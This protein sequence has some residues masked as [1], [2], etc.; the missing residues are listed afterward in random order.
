MITIIT[1]HEVTRGVLG[2]FRVSHFSARDRR[3]V[4]KAFLENKLR[5]GSTL[6]GFEEDAPFLPEPWTFSLAESESRVSHVSHPEE[7]V[8]GR[9]RPRHAASRV[10]APAKK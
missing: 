1:P 4:R 9:A 2:A 10:Y 3:I 7:K 6:Y 8:P 5:L